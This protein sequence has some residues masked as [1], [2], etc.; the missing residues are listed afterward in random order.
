MIQSPNDPPQANQPSSRPRVLRR[1]VVVLPS[2]LTLANLF[3]GVYA[4]VSASRGQF[5]LAGLLVVLGGVADAL[6][7]R[8]AT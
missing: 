1:G 8:V 3:C 5:D 6:D 7:G 4:I 2:G